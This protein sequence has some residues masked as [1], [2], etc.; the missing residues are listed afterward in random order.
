MSLS[1]LSLAVAAQAAA[2]DRPWQSIDRPWRDYPIGTHAR[3]ISGEGLW[4]KTPAGWRSD[5]GT[6][7]ET[8]LGAYQV[9]FPE[10]HA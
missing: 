3:T 2:I 9:R 10:A 1:T 7:H 6:V 4:E 8:P 5:A